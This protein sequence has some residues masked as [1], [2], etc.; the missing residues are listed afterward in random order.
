MA[1]KKPEVKAEVKAP[2]PP[3]PPAPLGPIMLGANKPGKI[4]PSLRGTSQDPTRKPVKVE[5]P[6]PPKG[7]K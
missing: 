2:P 4:P 6:D 5:R 3:P 7:E 1:E